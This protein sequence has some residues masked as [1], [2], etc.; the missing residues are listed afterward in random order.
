MNSASEICK[1]SL[2][3]V[4]PDESARLTKD[5]LELRAKY[6]TLKKTYDE[7][8][9]ERNILKASVEEKVAIQELESSGDEVVDINT[10]KKQPGRPRKDVK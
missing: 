4:A 8:C 1:R 10:V 5:L 6:I 2:T 9:A 7:V 3:S